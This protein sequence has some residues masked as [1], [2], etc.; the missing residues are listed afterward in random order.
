MATH[1]SHTISTKMGQCAALAQKM[2]EKGKFSEGR[3][4]TENDF[5]GYGYTNTTQV[6]CLNLGV[7][8][9]QQ[10]SHTTR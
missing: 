1:E 3:P 7:L 9:L 6:N 8:P 2:R 4:R 5:S 10:I